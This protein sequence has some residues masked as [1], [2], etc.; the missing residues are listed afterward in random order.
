MF[1]RKHNFVKRR[2]DEGT[3][4]QRYWASFKHAVD[5][6]VYAMEV[7]HNM[8]IIMIATIVTLVLGY[9]LEISTIEAII[10]IMC[11]C[12]VMACEMINTAIEAVVD[13]IT[14]KENDL[15]RI[16]KDSVSSATLILSFMS[17][18]IGLIIFV[19]KIIE[20]F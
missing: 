8:L 14:L 20:L 18:I 15:A 11:I 13:L 17:L 16:A 10:I 12:L 5:G 3:P 2:K 9:A 7:E 1:I 19:P 6:I 4:L